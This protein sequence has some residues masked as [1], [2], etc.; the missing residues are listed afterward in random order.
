MKPFCGDVIIIGAGVAG[1][2][3]AAQ[4]ARR[5]L[6]VLLLEA[7]RFPRDK[8]C[9][10]CLNPRGQAVLERAGRLT[11]LRQLGGR[12]IEQMQIQLGNASYLWKI[13]EMLVTERSLMDQWLAKQAQD[14]GA[15]FLDGAPATVLPIES[16]R[17]RLRTVQYEVDG[18][19]Q[20]AQARIVVVADGLTQSSLRKLPEFDMRVEGDPRV[21][22]HALS[23]IR[24]WESPPRSRLIMAVDSLGYV[25]I[26]PVSDDV[27]DIAAAIDPRRLS[28]D[29]RPAQAI[30]DI[31]R[32][33]GV[34]TPAELE[35]YHWQTTPPLGRRSTIFS[36]YRII[37]VGDALGYVEPFTGEGMANA[38]SSAELST[39][40]IESHIDDWSEHSQRI[41]RSLLNR[42][43]IRKQWLCRS[44]TQFIR[45]PTTAL[46]AAR[47]CHWMPPI[48]SWAMRQVS[49]E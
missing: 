4:L 12:S 39:S 40:F 27:L 29:F 35:S 22:V 48:R 2:F 19:V 26:A 49:C 37:V 46:W 38:L 3:C 5:G 9:G 42:N 28:R 17:D 8:V 43:L 13:P 1:A 36:S 23:K 21:G 32:R 41:W 6:Q 25:G 30:A 16:E 47:I 11:A 18:E 10:C 20:H 15:A 7:K 45:D 24:D 14:D 34:C 31:L 44:L 33:C